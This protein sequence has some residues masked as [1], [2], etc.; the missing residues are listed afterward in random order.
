MG[1]PDNSAVRPT[2]ENLHR[3]RIRQDFW[4]GDREVTR[5]QFRRL[6]SYAPEGT[7]GVD[8]DLPVTGVTWKEASKFCEQLSALEGKRY[9][10]PT[11]TQWEY[12]CRAGA[13][14]PFS[15]TGSPN[16]MGWH[17]GIPGPGRLHLGGLKE[18]NQ[19]GLYDFHGNAAEWCLD[20]YVAKYSDAVDPADP[21][22]DSPNVLR[23]VRG[24]SFNS[25]PADC[26]SA[27]RDKQHP[28]KARPDLGFRVV[29]EELAPAE[30]PA[31]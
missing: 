29:I 26:R 9:V 13:D 28:S 7:E 15:G 16:Q 11:E 4:I 18:R 3:V 19:W 31:R 23:V 5:G 24:G 17:L 25:L 1:T 10:L 12:A 22:D 6:M 30:Q 14:A 20:R 8:D 27:A 2:D 21:N